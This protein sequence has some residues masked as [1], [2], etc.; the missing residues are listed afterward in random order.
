M[1]ANI[2]LQD[3]KKL[4]GLDGDKYLGIT[5]VQLR[6]IYHHLFRCTHKNEYL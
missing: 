6:V 4:I 2:E 1:N 5:A 3:N